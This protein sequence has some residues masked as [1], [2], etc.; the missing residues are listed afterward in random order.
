ML[1]TNFITRT[2]LAELR[3]LLDQIN[4]D[5][6]AHPYRIE[7]DNSDQSPPFK[8][9][10]YEGCQAY[11]QYCI[12]DYWREHSDQRKHVWY[13]NWYTRLIE[14]KTA[15]KDDRDDYSDP[16]KT[17]DYVQ[18]VLFDDIWRNVN[19]AFATTVDALGIHLTEKPDTRNHS[20][21]VFFLTDE[22]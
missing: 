15:D 3:T 1:R 19:D 7:H 16:A 21:T 22:Y 5:N 14:P 18:G 17:L 13:I 12:G 4:A 6:K 2:Q 11:V 10:P 20:F 9:T 8:H